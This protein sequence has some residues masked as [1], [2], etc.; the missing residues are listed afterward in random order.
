ML[1][2]R[3]IRARMKTEAEVFC[4][5]TVDST[6]AVACRRIA[7]GKVSRALFMASAQTAG[8]GRRG[9]SFYSPDGTG[10]YLSV[11][12]PVSENLADDVFLTCGAAVAVCH[13][14]SDVCGVEAGIKWVNDL[15]VNGRKV[16]GILCQRI[17]GKPVAVIGV[18][19]NLTTSDFPEEIRF[20]A[21]SIGKEVSRE[22]L[23][24]AVAEELFSLPQAGER[25]M[26]EYRKRSVLTGKEITMEIAG[27]LRTGT[28]LG[29]DAR[30]GLIVRTGQG[31][32]VL[33]SGEI[34][35]REC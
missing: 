31:T 26:E 23:G 6:N 8:R 10:L 25:W 24:A 2:P 35:V 19:I 11:I 16:C 32:E 14:L 9:R 4:F 7:E 17:P 22:V 12:L 20:R 28:V 34:T 18:G 1:D 5:Q 29:I 15:Q 30:G 27:Q 21:G 33:T 13:A 3:E